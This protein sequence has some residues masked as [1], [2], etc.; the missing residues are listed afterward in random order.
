LIDDRDYNAMDLDDH[1]IAAKVKSEPMSDYNMPKSMANDLEP[2]ELREGGPLMESMLSWGALSSCMKPEP[3]DVSGFPQQ[4]QVDHAKLSAV[5]QEE[6]AAYASHL[7]HLDELA[8]RRTAAR[9]SLGDGDDDEMTRPFGEGRLHHYDPVAQSLA[10]AHTMPM[11]MRPTH[12][13]NSKAINNHGIRKKLSPELTPVEQ[14]RRYLDRMQSLRPVNLAKIEHAKLQLR[15]AQN[16]QARKAKE[17]KGSFQIGAEQSLSD[18]LV[19]RKRTLPE[20][21]AWSSFAP[22]PKRSR[23]S[24]DIVEQT[25][26]NMRTHEAI[27]READG[28]KYPVSKRNTSYTY[29]SDAQPYQ[30]ANVALGYVQSSGSMEISCKGQRKNDTEPLLLVPA[31]D[32]LIPVEDHLEPEVKSVE[33]L[34]DK[35]LGTYGPSIVSCKRPDYEAVVQQLYYRARRDAYNEVLVKRVS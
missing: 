14:A 2:G 24:D 33:I 12:S 22:S 32:L 7:A 26:T 21:P 9:G 11:A 15:R 6:R 30:A 8:R 1:C 4:Q 19:S 28:A 3:Q 10:K 20:A 35:V 13:G 27:V 34:Y 16:A 29:T 17:R 31:A 5:P 23:R 18:V 25:Q